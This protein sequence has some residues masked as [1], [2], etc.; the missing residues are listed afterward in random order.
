MRSVN[1]NR[2]HFYLLTG[3]LQ[4]DGTENFL[5]KRKDPRGDS[6]HHWRTNQFLTNNDRPRDQHIEYLH[7]IYGGYKEFIPTSLF[8]TGQFF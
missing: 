6:R 4:N 1:L 7:D 5:P 3:F 2:L 8:D